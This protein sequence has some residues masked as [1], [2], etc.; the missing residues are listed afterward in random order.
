[1]NYLF[2]MSEF[3][4]RRATRHDC[5]SI[6]E[7]IHELAVFEGMEDQVKITE[8]IVQRDG[9]DTDPPYF[10]CFIAELDRQTIG[11]ALYFY[12]YSSTEGGPIMYLEDLYIKEQYRGKGY[13]KQLFKTVVEEGKRQECFCMQW[14][15]LN[16]NTKALDF[17]KSVGAFDLTLAKKIHMYRFTSQGMETL[18]SQ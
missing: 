2:S 5:K 10:L 18:L 16:W 11:Y 1:M 12:S 3:T 6:I 7:L 13:G 9:F 15:V 4:I 17:Y 8:K 14:C